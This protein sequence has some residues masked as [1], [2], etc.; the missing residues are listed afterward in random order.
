M[1]VYARYRSS[2]MLQEKFLRAIDWFIAP[3]ART[4]AAVLGRAR[5]FVFSLLF[6]PALGHAIS[7]YLF[8]SDKNRGFPF[9][10]RT[11]TFGFGAAGAGE[12][13][14][15]RGAGRALRLNTTVIA[16]GESMVL[17]MRKPR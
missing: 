1:K 16:A 14:L 13:R 7:V 3:Q 2:S 10:R 17:V 6:G 4:D 12:P 5:I 9:S 11:L 15:P 8:I